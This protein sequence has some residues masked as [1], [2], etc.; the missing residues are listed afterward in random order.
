MKQFTFY[1]MNN[2]MALFMVTIFILIGVAFL[3]LFERKILGY[4]HY[5]K[6]PNK[7]SMWGL[8]QPFS[9]VMKLLTKEFFYPKKSN[10]NFFFIAPFIMFMLI[11]SMWMI[12]PFHTNLFKWDLSSL[13]ILCL[14]SMSVYGL[15]MSGWSSNSHFSMLGSIRSIAQSISYEITLSISLLLNLF[16]MNSLNI[17][18][19]PIL[20]KY[21]WMIMFMWPSSMIMMLS[22]LAELNRTPFDLSE[23]ESELV[24]GFNIEY[25]S[26]GFAMIFM[27]E[28]TSIMFLMFLFNLMY[29]CNNLLIMN[30]YFILILFIYFIVW[31]RLTL[32]RIRY[33]L[34]MYF[35]W[36]FMLPLILILFCL[37]LL[38]KLSME[39][40][41]F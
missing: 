26:H 18:N 6:G 17:M 2:I 36:I 28:Y 41:I 38:M 30:F 35:C 13:F 31:S 22:M 10:F 39:L 19:T 24:S 14:L 40:M 32:P 37:Y 11:F 12:Y 20:Q 7:I 34:L 15:M 16:L 27:S 8:L 3:T 4:T 9:D 5:R 21:L 29:F 25:S 23:G 33:D 1:F